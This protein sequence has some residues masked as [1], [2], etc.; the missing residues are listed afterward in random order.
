MPGAL[1]DRQTHAAPLAV[2]PNVT[3]LSHGPEAYDA[4]IITNQLDIRTFERWARLTGRGRLVP[5]RSERPAH[6]S[7]QRG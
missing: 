6:V 7:V 2:N 3:N 1:A 5:V 4:V